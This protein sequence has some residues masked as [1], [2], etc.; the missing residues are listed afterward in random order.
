MVVGSFHF[1]GETWGS[2]C[3]ASMVK[4]GCWGVLNFLRCS[5]EERSRQ[6]V[7]VMD[8]PVFM[9]MKWCLSHDKCL[10]PVWFMQKTLVQGPLSVLILISIS[11]SCYYHQKR[12]KDVRLN[13]SICQYALS[14]YLPRNA[15]AWLSRISPNVGMKCAS[16]R[17]QKIIK[18]VI[19]D[20]V[21]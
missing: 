19:I 20:V 1:H 2:V 13:V 17:A 5:S 9:S 3:K 18:I 6:H 11:S 14:C 16:P 10:L 21:S 12:N 8:R 4:E 15:W 7:L